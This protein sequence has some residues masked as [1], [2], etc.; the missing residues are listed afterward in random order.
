[1]GGSVMDQGL[2]PGPTVSAVLVLGSSVT[3]SASLAGTRVEAPVRPPAP[4]MTSSTARST[5]TSVSDQSS[6]VGVRSLPQSRTTTPSTPMTTRTQRALAAAHRPVPPTGPSASA[7][8]TVCRPP[9]T[10]ERTA[11]PGALGP[12][13]QAAPTKIQLRA[14]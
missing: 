4:I 2:P 5:T 3:V 10:A 1:G 13:D 7:A 8:P 12:G 14:R 11:G 6:R 9:D